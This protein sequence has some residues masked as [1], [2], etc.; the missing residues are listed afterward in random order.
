MMRMLR[1]RSV[2]AM[3]MLAAPA[4]A[5]SGSFLAECGY[6]R[7]LPDDPI[8]FPRLP[9]M[10]HRHDF[11]GARNVNAFSTLISMKGNGTTC[12]LAGDTAGYW[13]PALYRNGVAI[14]PG[15]VSPTGIKARLRVYYATSNLAKG[16]LVEVPPPDLRVVA[17]NGHATSPA[18]NLVREI[19]WGCSDN[20]V[21]GKSLTPPASCPTGLLSVH[22]GFPNCWDG[23]LTHVN[24]TPHLRYPVQ[25]VCQPPFTH[26]LPRVT[27]RWEYP[28]GTTTGTITL[29]SGPAYT[30]HG[31]F[32]QTWDQNVLASLVQRCLNSGVSCGVL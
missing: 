13:T 8:V 14:P 5:G 3:L 19:Y 4:Y 26:A 7:S 24:D 20:S 21:S 27:F 30:M 17:G 16:T 6:D 11:I 25:G 18:G 2:A 31:D 29:A 1:L 15:G 12:H 22:I 10:S 28:V 23:V 9:T 32:W